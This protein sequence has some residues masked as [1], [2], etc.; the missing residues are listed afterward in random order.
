MDALQVAQRD[1]EAWNR[2][3]AAASIA[4]FVPGGTYEEVS[5]IKAA[6]DTDQPLVDLSRAIAVTVCT[7]VF[8]RIDDTASDFPAVASPAPHW[9]ARS[10]KA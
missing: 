4:T 7:N 9:W 8:N 3:D 6:G 10:G 1:F 2:R 5:A